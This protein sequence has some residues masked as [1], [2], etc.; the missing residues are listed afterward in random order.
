LGYQALNA[1]AAKET[2]LH[3]IQVLEDAQNASKVAINK[4]R[5]VER[6]KGS[7]NISAQKVDDAIAEM[8]DAQDLDTLLARRVQAISI[9]LRSALQTHSRQ[10]HGDAADMLL[11]FARTKI[12]YERQT[13]KELEVLR[14]ELRGVGIKAVPR[15]QAVGGRQATATATA[16]VG[17]SFVPPQPTA[18]AAAPAEPAPHPS[19]AALP[20]APISQSLY[21]PGQAQYNAPQP[22]LQPSPYRPAYAPP[23]PSAPPAGAHPMAQSMFL[24][25]SAR[26][27]GGAPSYGTQRRKLDDRAA[28]RS[29]ANM[30]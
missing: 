23:P 16:T 19:A 10:A 14:P 30:F 1:R 18:T 29:L 4:R 26:P 5:T 12:I 7:S 2:L 21:L 9:N 17:S 25:P 22:H 11:E 28:A 27:P 8:Q 3:R 24:P 15:G 20:H 6:L 13:L